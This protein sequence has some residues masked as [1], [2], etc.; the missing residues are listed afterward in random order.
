MK[1]SA[2]TSPFSFKNGSE[3]GVLVIHGFTSTPASVRHIGENIARAGFDVEG[4]LLSGHGRDWREANACR[5]QAWLDDVERAYHDL[6]GRCSRVFVGGLSMGGALSLYLAEN[7]PEIAGVFPINHA[8]VFSRDWRLALLPVLKLIIPSLPKIGGDLKDP[9]QEEI[10]FDRTPL[11]ATHE[12]MKMVRI[13]KDGLPRVTQPCLIFKSRE[14][15]VI[16]VES[17]VHTL[18]RISSAE[19]RIAWLENS[20]HVATQ[21]YDRDVI[22]DETVKFIKKHAGR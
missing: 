10:T 8:A 4:P 5:Y 12:L 7:H 20:Y 15:H 9:R 22:V 17:A 1:Q 3:V 18:E 11:A 21:D 14:D 6:T 2:E 13:I 16:P 19:K